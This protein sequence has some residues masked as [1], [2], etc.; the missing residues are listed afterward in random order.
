MSSTSPP[1]RSSRPL[2]TGAGRPRPRARARGPARVPLRVLLEAAAVAAAAQDARRAPPACG[3]S[4]RRRRRRRG[5]ARRRARGRRRRPV[6]TVTS[7]RS[8]TSWPAPKRNSPQAAALASFSTT[9]GRSTRSSSSSLSVDVAPGEVRGEQ[10]RAP[11]PCRC[12]RRRRCRPPS[13]VVPRGAAR[14]RA[15]RWR[16]RSPRRRRP[17]DSTRSSSRIV[18]SVVDHAA[19]DL[20]AADVDPAREA[21]C[22]VLRPVAGSSLVEVDVLDARAPRRLAGSSGTAVASSPAAACISDAAAAARCA[23]TSGWPAARRA[24]CGRSGSSVHSARAGGEVLVDVARRGGGLVGEPGQP[25]RRGRRRGRAPSG[26]RAEQL[27][28]LLG[29][30]A[31]VA[32]RPPGRPGRPRVPPVLTSRLLLL[33]EPHLQLPVA[34]RARPATR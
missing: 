1:A 9:T 4:R 11:G 31:D 19:G 2:R 22:V 18:P 17:G 3:R 10:H 29:H 5:R 6:P 15:R 23:R 34:P 21:H 32:R 33:L 27:G 14:S 30:A 12:S 16:P 20:G 13:I 26:E 7:S 25:V 28:G 8:S 24:R